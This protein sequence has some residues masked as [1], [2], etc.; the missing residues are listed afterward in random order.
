MN[1]SEKLER[2]QPG[3][4]HQ[5]GVYRVLSLDGGGAKGF[6][7]LGVLHE[8]EGM[9]NRPLYESFDLIFGTS[10]G[11]II[12]ALIALGHSVDKVHALYKQRVPYVMA[13]KTRRA[14]TKALSDLA[15]EVFEDKTFN[16]LKTDVGIVATKWAIDRPMIFKGNVCQ[17]YGRIGTFEPGFERWTPAVGQRT[18]TDKWDLLT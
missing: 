5:D 18:G 3:D 15:T 9:L 11:A 12:T 14:R 13:K 6:Y 1:P 8:I 4:H 16:D 7:T 17:A 2:T 10:T